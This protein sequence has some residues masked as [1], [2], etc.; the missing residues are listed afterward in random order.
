MIAFIEG[1]LV[2]KEP[3]YVIVNVGGI[4]YQIF[5]SI[6]TSFGLQPQQ[7]CK[8]YTYFLVR[9]D[10]Q[11]LY[12]FKDLAE[13]KLFLHLISVS[14][15][16]ANTAM[17]ILSSLSTSE[18]L[19][20]IVE[21]DI[22]TIRQIKGIG[23]KTAQRLVLELKDKVS[24]ELKSGKEQPILPTTSTSLNTSAIKEEAILALIT[25]GISRPSAEK[26]V[27]SI[28]KSHQGTISLEDLIKHALKI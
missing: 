27:A 2:Q 1:S 13:K 15:I 14:G 10:A 17:V 21:E 18:I 19:T 5:V 12:G 9:E 26:N 24:K 23:L 22:A 4:G 16:G 25:L 7:K 20:A 11:L 6:N 3:T 28:W 8:L